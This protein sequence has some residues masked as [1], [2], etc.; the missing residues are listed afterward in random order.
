MQN[1]CVRYDQ[2]KINDK[3]APWEAEICLVKK[4]SYEFNVFKW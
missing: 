3:I 2:H 4:L 1:I